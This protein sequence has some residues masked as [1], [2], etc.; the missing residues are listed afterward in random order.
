MIP[1][2]VPRP[3]TREYAAFY[4][5]YIEEVAGRDLGAILHEQLSTFRS[6]LGELSESDAMARYAPGKWSVK[7]VLGHLTDSERVFAYRALRISRGD[8]TPLPGFDENDYVEAA[9][10]DRRAMDDLL[11]EW[12]G[13]RASTLTLLRSVDPD[14]WE[15][16]VVANGTE[17]S[18]R[19]LAHIIPGHVRHHQQVLRERYGL[20]FPQP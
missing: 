2:N 1:I 10:F 15:R 3:E 13:V 19:A 14:A 7:E 8:T 11:E 5:G 17:V 6:V 4:A 18:L 9:G 20:D 16:R 12:S